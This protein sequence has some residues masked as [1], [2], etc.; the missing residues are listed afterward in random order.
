M[1]ERDV[2]RRAWEL[3]K[4][5]GATPRRAQAV[6]LVLGAAAGCNA[7][8]GIGDFSVT[9]PPADASTSGGTVGGGS[10]GTG[11]DSGDGGTAGDGG[12]GGSAG[13]SSADVVVSERCS[14]GIDD[15]LDG[16]IDCFDS[17]CGPDPACAGFCRDA[18]TLPCNVVRRSQ[19]SSGPGST[20]RIGPP[21]YGCGGGRD[22]PGPEYGYRVNVPAGQRVFAEVFGLDADLSLFAIGAA[23]GAQCDARSSCLAAGATGSGPVAEALSFAGTADQDHYVVVDG[24]AAGSYSISIQCSDFDG[25]IPARAIEAGQTLT[26]SLVLGSAPNVTQKLGSYTCAGG[27]RSFPEAAFMFT[28]TADGAY[29]IDLTDISTNV[30]L[31]VLAAPHCNGTC[32]SQNSKSTNPAGGDESIELTATAGTTYYVVV[33]AYGATSFTLSVTNL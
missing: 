16:S 33:D 28:P 15:D 21:V 23:A 1:G 14:G 6:L 25:C 24:L 17:D 9:D 2:P 26:G 13:T 32:L 10:G 4:V 22:E 18:E 20:S 12:G 11:G 5:F 31:F 3:L 19:Q 8:S 29:R 7:I 27:N 30:D